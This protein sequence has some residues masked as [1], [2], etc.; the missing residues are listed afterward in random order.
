MFKRFAQKRVVLSLSPFSETNEVQRI[1]YLLSIGRA[2]RN[3]FE[4]EQMDSIR[5]YPYDY[6][7]KGYP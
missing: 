4:A 5:G 3:K 2:M 6:K 1:G 7:D